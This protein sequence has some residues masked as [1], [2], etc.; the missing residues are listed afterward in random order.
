[1]GQSDRQSNLWSQNDLHAVG[2]DVILPPV[3]PPGELDEIQ[4]HILFWPTGA[5]E[6]DRA[7]ATCRTRTKNFVKFGHIYK[8]AHRNTF[9]ALL[10]PCNNIRHRKPQQAVPRKRVTPDVDTGQQ[11][12]A[13]SQ[14][15]TLNRSLRRMRRDGTK[16]T[17]KSRRDCTEV[18]RRT[19]PEPL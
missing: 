11:R 16:T 17:Q 4:R 6:E 18:G 15:S 2:H 13:P 9:A 7:T 5:S 10:G 8:H 14:S 3:P 19:A 12:A 1:M